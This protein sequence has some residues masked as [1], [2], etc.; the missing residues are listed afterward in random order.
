MVGRAFFVIESAAS[1]ARRSATSCARGTVVAMGSRDD[2]SRCKDW[3]IDERAVFD[4]RIARCR[5]PWTKWQRFVCQGYLL[6]YHGRAADS[7]TEAVRLLERSLREVSPIEDEWAADSL[8]SLA[9]F[10]LALGQ[11]DRARAHI[12]AAAARCPATPKSGGLR[13]RIEKLSRQIVAV[14][15]G[16]RSG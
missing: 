7:R 11:P 1:L 13:E 16:A 3:T 10:A 12:D 6:F 9:E 15:R 14:T 8:A 2:W 4:G 5:Q